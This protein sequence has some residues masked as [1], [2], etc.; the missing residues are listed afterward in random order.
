MLDVGGDDQATRPAGAGLRQ[1]AKRLDKPDRRRCR[2]CRPGR[3]RSAGAGPVLS[4]ASNSC[5]ALRSWYAPSAVRA[6]GGPPAAPGRRPARTRYAVCPR[7]TEP[8]RRRCPVQRAAPADADR[9]AGRPAHRRSPDRHRTAG[10][11]LS[12]PRPARPADRDGLGGLDA[13]KAVAGT[14]GRDQNPHRSRLPP[15]VRH[16][17][18][19]AGSECMP[20][21]RPRRSNLAA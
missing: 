15:A 8:T 13:V 4:A 6:V 14:V 11:G 19:P 10:P 20:E 21:D 7:R 3:R 1:S 5:P 17:S 18:I 12:S 9:P 16:P 2:R